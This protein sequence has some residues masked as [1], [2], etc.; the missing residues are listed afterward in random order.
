M[1]VCVCTSSLLAAGLGVC[2]GGDGNVVGASP[3]ETLETE[4][5]RGKVSGTGL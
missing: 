5:L 2:P 1:C 3:H 4:V